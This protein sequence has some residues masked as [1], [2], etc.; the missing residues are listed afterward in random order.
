MNKRQNKKQKGGKVLGKGRDGC[1]VDP[2]FVCPNSKFTNQNDKISKLIKLSGKSKKMVDM[3]LDEFKLGQWIKSNDQ[4]GEMFLPG[5][6][7]C[8]MKLNKR[9]LTKQQKDDLASCD[10]E[11]GSTKRVL[12]IVMKKGVDFEDVIINMNDRQVIKTLKYLLNTMSHSVYNML[13]CFMDIKPQNLLYTET[14]QKIYPVIIDFSADHVLR[15]FEDYNNFLKGFHGATYFFWP[16]EI[17]LLL[18]Y[19][20]KNKKMTL[21]NTDKIKDIFGIDNNYLVNNSYNIIKSMTDKFNKYSLDIF[22]KIQSYMICNAILVSIGHT[23]GDDVNEILGLG[24]ILDP[25]KRYGI[26]QILDEIDKRFPNIGKNNKI[27]KKDLTQDI[28]KLFKKYESNKKPSNKKTK[29]PEIPEPGRRKLSIEKQISIKIPPQKRKQFSIE[30]QKSIKISPMK[31]NNKKHIKKKPI[32][33]K[34]IKDQN[35][36]SWICDNFK[37]NL[38]QALKEKSNKM[39]NPKT[40]KKITIN[41][42]VFKKLKKECS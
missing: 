20:Y 33:K 24:T 2:V 19:E 14:K 37:K 34:S 5:V 17:N 35:V 7:M 39:I 8:Q 13:A 28:A 12:N 31:K 4:K 21:S 25:N 3:Y 27:N 22:D 16:L 26:K 10:I 32:K 40:G 9:D 42:G 29:S 1:A 30:K 36:N 6:E 23:V 41:K 18:N 15:D 11:T 38:N